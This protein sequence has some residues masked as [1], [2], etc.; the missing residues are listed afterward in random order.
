MATD[1]INAGFRTILCSADAKFFS[2]QQLV[3]FDLQFL[4]DLPPSVDSCGENGEFHT[5]VF[6]GPLFKKPIP[7]K[8]GEVVKKAYTYQKNSDDGK[9]EKLESVFWFQDLLIL[10]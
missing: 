5:F 9:I 4:N 10:A 7:I 8:V 2:E 1:F 6:D 3:E